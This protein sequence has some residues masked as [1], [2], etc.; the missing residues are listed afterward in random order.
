MVSVSQEL[1]IVLCKAIDILILPSATS[2]TPE[3][4][5]QRSC[6]H[7]HSGITTHAQLGELLFAHD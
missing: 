5:L 7:E 3:G 4:V 2:G 6:K 1:K